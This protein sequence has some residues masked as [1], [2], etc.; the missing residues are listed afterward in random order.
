[1]KKGWFLILLFTAVLIL[2]MLPMASVSADEGPLHLGIFAD[3]HAHDTDSPSKGEL[4]STYP[5]RLTA[6]IEAMNAWPAE[7]VIN[8]GDFVNGNFVLGAESMGDPARI[9]GILDKAEE[10]YSTFNGPRYYVIGNH[11]VYDLSKEEFLAH[12]SAT[13]TYQS[14]DAGG[15]HF[16]ILDA[17]YNKEGEDLSHVGWAVQG[18]IPQPELEW[19]EED[20]AETD[21]PT[22]V[23]VHQRLDVDFDLLSGGGPEI[24]NNKAVQRILEDSGVVIAVFQ[25][26]DHEN[27]HNVIDKIHYVTF[28]QLANERGSEPS[29]AYVTLNPAARTIEVKGAG[30]QIDLQLEY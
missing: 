2:T 5:Q 25:G 23:C 29:W 16:I 11:E 17:Q 27:A 24:L 18:N 6:C 8:L 7:L 9:P 19:L 21:K 4:M 28:D 1:M 14:F 10:I 20:L 22:I 30:D 12:T 15:Y 26:H 3:L 13:N